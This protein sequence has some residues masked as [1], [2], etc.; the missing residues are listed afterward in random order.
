MVV[1]KDKSFNQCMAVTKV[2]NNT[3]CQNFAIC[4]RRCFYLSACIV[5]ILTMYYVLGTHFNRSTTI[6]CHV[7]YVYAVPRSMYFVHIVHDIYVCEL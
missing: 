6:R 1:V 4:D 5:S 3:H 7:L 2:K